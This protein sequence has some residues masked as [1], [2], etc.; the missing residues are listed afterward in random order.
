M[1]RLVIN[2]APP[3]IAGGLGWALSGNPYLG[4]TLFAATVAGK[5]FAAWRCRPRQVRS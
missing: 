4:L 2:A 1:K 3:L 5:L